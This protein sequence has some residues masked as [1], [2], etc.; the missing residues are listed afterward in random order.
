MSFVCKIVGSHSLP[1]TKGLKDKTGVQ[2]T[3]AL[4]IMII[5]ISQVSI[6]F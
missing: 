3:H 2:I 1:Q 5:I 4:I 6:T